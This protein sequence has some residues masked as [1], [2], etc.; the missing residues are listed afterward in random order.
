M[1]IPDL[2][3]SL[4]TVAAQ[5]TA[6]TQQSAQSES[7]QAALKLGFC[8]E[9]GRTVLRERSHFGPLRIQKP[10]YPE[11]DGCC[12]V[13]IVHPPGGIAGGDQL[14]MTV[15]LDNRTH[16][17]VTTPGATKWYGGK[18]QHSSQST[19]ITLRPGAR[20]EWLPQENIVFNQALA[21]SKTCIDVTE[22]TQLIAWDVTVL[23]RKAMQE[24]FAQGCFQPSFELLKNGQLLWADYGKINGGDALLSSPLGL[25]GRHVFGTLCA[26]GLAT[27][28]V[29]ERDALL[30]R[31]REVGLAEGDSAGISYLPQGVLLVRVISHQAETARHYLCALWQIL[32]PIMMK[33]APVMPRIWA[34]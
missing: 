12:H 7:W 1:K 19:H 30:E 14:S 27:L 26:Y 23:G 18:P 4:A 28:T 21:C 10:L 3:I 20:L 24:T 32:R 22:D 8:H 25:A 9:H 11:G 2:P 34:T 15:R 16:A 29:T 13:L 33:V 5:A 6:L 31:L 17:F